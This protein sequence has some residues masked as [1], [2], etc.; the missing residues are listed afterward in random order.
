MMNLQPGTVQPSDAPEQNNSE[1]A[2]Q[3][4]V[5]NRRSLITEILTL[6]FVITGAV[7]VIAL[8]G[9]T[10]TSGAVIRNNLT[11]WA[12]QWAGELNELGAPFYL[13]DRNE[14]VLDVERFVEKYPEIHSV[15]WYRPDGSVFTSIDKNGP[16]E[17]SVSPLPASAIADLSE[18]AGL[19][20]A[21][22]L[23]ED[24]ERN[25]RFR[26]SGPIWVESLV[27]DGLFGLDADGAK[28]KV[29]LLG[30]VAV[31]LDFS[32]Y[33][34]AFLRRLALAGVVLV[35]LLFTSWILG[36]ALLK[37][38][39]RPLSELQE[40]LS[41]IAQ[42]RMQVTF[43][44][45]RHK[46]TQA[47]VTALRDTLLALEKREQH[48]LH[49]ANHDSLTGLYNRHQLG[50]E[51][52]AEVASCAENGKRSALCFVDLDQFKY[53]NDT[54]GHPAGDQ[55]L[56]LAAQQLRDGVRAQDFVA[57]F[58]G[59]EFI[60]LL[61]NVTRPQAR[62]IANHLLSQMRSLSHVEQGHLFHLQ[63]SIG[64]ALIAS[65][66]FDADELIAQADMAC[67]TAK[68]HGRNRVEFYN[69]S[70]K[71][72]E[73]MVQDVNWMRTIREALEKD[74]FV[75]HYQ[76]ILHIKS[77][78]VS[79]YEA[80]L[81]LTTDRGLVGPH[82]F[83]PAV[84]RFGFMADIDRWVIAR[85]IRVLSEFTGGESRLRISVNV[86][87][88]AFENESFAVSVR[89]LL[90]EHGVPGDQICF[91]ITEQMAVRFAVKTDKQIAML[92]DLGCRIAVDDFGTGYS[93]FSYLKR[94]P[95]DY[96]KIDGSFIKDLT[97][98]RVDQSMVRMIGEVAKA[99]NLE[100]VAEYVESAAALALLKKYGI[101]Y[102]QGY[103]VGRAVP[104]PAEFVRGVETYGQRVISPEAVAVGVAIDSHEAYGLPEGNRV[105]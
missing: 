40:P 82:S 55:L 10:W 13:R 32:A 103:F 6:Q 34:S 42:G 84:T 98:N 58:G 23:R 57:R 3:A 37:R 65:T 89:N 100:T 87:G 14:A 31:D 99:A 35:A 61:R 90:K 24:I 30:F 19:S 94:L 16:V 18:K 60:V 7:T 93:S 43:P 53:I 75:L 74:H 21:Y 38:A 20:P 46:E 5:A 64:I 97:R 2:R 71:Q 17:T 44:A 36:R 28:T 72:S 26:L 95:V 77:G 62:A 66:R 25:R 69:V 85:A 81:R 11:Y 91:E 67:Q 41:R 70:G 8:A 76:P 96:L 79:H 9:L 12:E 48:L 29:E 68:A 56:K 45:T 73:Q 4:S 59:D 78:V 50:P 80:L 63:C 86:S 83:L 39:L 101:D 105:N 51:L 102:A 33:Q 22:L 88:S 92:R 54:C 15:T 104:Q 1:P 47:I 52:D 27:G 49:V